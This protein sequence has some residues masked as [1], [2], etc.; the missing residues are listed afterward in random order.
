MLV[1]QIGVGQGGIDVDCPLDDLSNGS[2]V[3]DLG[4]ASSPAQ[5]SVL[6]SFFVSD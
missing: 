6:L 2:G 5:L 4:G 3:S 1:E